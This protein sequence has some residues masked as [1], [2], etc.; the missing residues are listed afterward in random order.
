VRLKSIVI[1]SDAAKKKL[2]K[3]ESGET[4]QKVNVVFVSARVC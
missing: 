2:E 4:A 1:Q 3:V